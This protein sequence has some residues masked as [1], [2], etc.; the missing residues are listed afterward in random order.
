MKHQIK[1]GI[2]FCLAQLGNIL[3][4][5]HIPILTYHSIDSSGSPIS[6]DEN[7]FTR[8]MEWLYE[9]D[10]RTVSL[11][12]FLERVGNGTV[13][14]GKKNVVLTFD[15]GFEN[16]YTVAFPV[17]KKFGFKATFFLSTAFLGTNS[18]W[19]EP[20]LD[21]MSMLSW[22][23]VKEMSQA[24]M[25]FGAHTVHHTDLTVV[26]RDHAEREINDSKDVIEDHLNKGVYFFCYPFGHYSWE[27]EFLVRRI[28]FLGACTTKYGIRNSR[29]DRYKLS[30]IGTAK[31]SNHFDFIAGILGTYDLYEAIRRLFP[32]KK[33]GSSL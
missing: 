14:S 33:P 16:N 25:D 24:G 7:Q 10:Y 11:N 1:K 32:V 29:D 5:D 28:G 13:S 21:R 6:M 27:L 19:L 12:S 31:F 15:D 9:H 18:H 22:E 17:L 23:Q 20:P 8:Q 2:S 4:F 26:D 30:R 3:T